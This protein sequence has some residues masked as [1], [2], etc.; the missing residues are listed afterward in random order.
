MPAQT[1][2]PLVGDLRKL[3]SSQLSILFNGEEL[4][5]LKSLG[6]V[7]FSR[8]AYLRI[9]K[10]DPAD[11][12]LGV[13]RQH[14]DICKRCG[15]A[16][17]IEFWYVDNDTS[18]FSGVERPDYQAMCADIKSGVIASDATI[19]AL[20]SA[21]LHRNHEEAEVFLQ[22]IYN[23][24]AHD[25]DIQVRTI[26]TGDFD[27]K[28]AAGRERARVDAVRAQA[29]SETISEAIKDV[30]P[31]KIRNGEPL[32]GKPKF[33][34]LSGG[35]EHHP[36][37]AEAIRAGAAMI[38]DGKS[39]S[40]VARDWNE[41]GLTTMQSGNPID[42][43][44][45]KNALVRHHTAGIGIHLGETYPGCWEP[46]LDKETWEKVRAELVR[47]GK[48]RWH[49]G[50]DRWLGTGLYLCGVCTETMYVSGG[51]YRCK[52][53]RPNRIG[54]AKRDRSGPKHASRVAATLDAMVEELLLAVLLSENISE[55][56]L[57]RSAEAE[58]DVGKLRRRRVEVE[59]EIAEARSLVGKPGWGMAAI[60]EA[61]ATLTV[62]LDAITEK[63]GTSA[64]MSSAMAE[65]VDDGATVEAWSRAPVKTRRRILNDVVTVTVHRSPLGLQRTTADHLS[66]DWHV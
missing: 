12:A 14:F 61:V 8:V 26:K 1:A 5:R 65:F 48:S 34:F 25:R 18:A 55:A 36:E 39:L 43:V 3:T 63:L 16:R 59:G 57:K 15:E 40:D 42:T 6:R 58:T 2:N 24:K 44:I 27:L 7:T 41:R 53:K 10:D 60:G 38:L 13:Q 21:R 33:G 35:I 28:T 32:N 30:W 9:S 17:P 37:Q 19:W 11:T 56:I 31:Q 64:T 47:D 22:L 4:I 23:P 20:N 50:E 49:G 45:V 54:H 52:S 29:Y 46:I 51:S 62:E 66:F